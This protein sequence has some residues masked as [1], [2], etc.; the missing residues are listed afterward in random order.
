MKFFF[1][2]LLEFFQAPSGE[3]SSKRL[4]W[5]L[6]IPFA[7]YGTYKLCIILIISEQS[8]M[9]VNLWNSFL[10]FS[11]VIGGFVTIDAITN[12]ISVLRNK[13]ESNIKN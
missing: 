7:T 3:M 4:S 9:A 11:A 2:K 6:T 10:I 8:E 13:N 1:K 12:L 5:L